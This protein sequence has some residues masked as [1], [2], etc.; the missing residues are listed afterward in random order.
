MNNY[1]NEKFNEDYDGFT[2]NIEKGNILAIGDSYELDINKEKDDVEYNPLFEFE[3]DKYENNKS[4]GR[5]KKI[6]E[7]KGRIKEKI[8]LSCG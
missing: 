3:V 2:F 1:S 4:F 5:F 8:V 6:N 7:P